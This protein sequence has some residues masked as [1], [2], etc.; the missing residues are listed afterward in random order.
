MQQWLWWCLRKLQAADWRTFFGSLAQNKVVDWAPK[1]WFDV[2]YNNH[3][4]FMSIIHNH[5][6]RHYCQ[7]LQQ[8]LQCID[9]GSTRSRTSYIYL[10]PCRYTIRTF[11]P[12]HCSLANASCQLLYNNLYNT[13]TTEL[14]RSTFTNEWMWDYIYTYS[15]HPIQFAKYVALYLECQ[16]A[17]ACQ[18]LHQLWLFH[19]GRYT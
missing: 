17:C 16:C 2:P 3:R 18:V 10:I 6:V 11:I 12:F 15:H 8:S 9:S 5:Y 4:L 14:L 19:A 13:C 7:Q 1:S